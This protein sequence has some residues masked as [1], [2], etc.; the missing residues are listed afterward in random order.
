MNEEFPSVPMV[1]L[2]LDSTRK[3]G[4]LER[5]LSE[6]SD[7]KKAFLIGTQM[8][9]KGHDFSDVELGIV[10][11]ADLGLVSHEVNAVE[12][13]SQLLIQVT[14]RV[15]RSGKSKIIVPVSYT[16]LTLPTT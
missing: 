8:I 15:G 6:I 7:T 3:K 13:L 16:H 12:K 10:I 2:D 1:R 9:A 14:G 5:L 4:S 11:D